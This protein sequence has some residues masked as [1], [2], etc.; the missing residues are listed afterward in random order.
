MWGAEYV[1]DLLGGTKKGFIED[2]FELKVCG[3]RHSLGK[4]RLEV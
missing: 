2:R 3:E 4:K 1:T